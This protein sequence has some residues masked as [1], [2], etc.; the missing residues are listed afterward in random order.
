MRRITLIKEGKH[1]IRMTGE[2][3][4]YWW[5]YKKITHE[6]EVYEK[7][8]RKTEVVN[9]DQSFKKYIEGDEQENYRWDFYDID[10]F[11]GLGINDFKIYYFTNANF[12]YFNNSQNAYIDIILEANRLG[13]FDFIPK[14]NRGYS[15]LFSG[16]YNDYKENGAIII[17]QGYGFNNALHLDMDIPKWLQYDISKLIPHTRL[18]VTLPSLKKY[19]GMNGDGFTFGY[20]PKEDMSEADKCKVLLEYA[21]LITHKK[22]RQL[23]NY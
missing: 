7:K 20:I 12:G 1:D 3:E 9:L 13:F 18:K 21:E 2:I 15:C 11:K 17:L 10:I 5:E 4:L 23:N 22:Q 14:D 16:K 8:E 6:G 19:Y